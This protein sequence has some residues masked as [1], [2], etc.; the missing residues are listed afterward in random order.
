MMM[1]VWQVIALLED[2]NGTVR[3]TAVQCLEELHRQVNYPAPP[4]ELPRPAG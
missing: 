1:I 4:G 3:E 2:S